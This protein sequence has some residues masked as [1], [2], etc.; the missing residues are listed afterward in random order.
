MPPAKLGHGFIEVRT[1]ADLIGWRTERTR[2]WLTRERLLIKK[3]RFYYTTAAKLRRAWPE[4][5]EELIA[6]GRV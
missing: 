4:V 6:C 3:G 1:V 5:I 2:R